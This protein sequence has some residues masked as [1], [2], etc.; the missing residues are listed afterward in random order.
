LNP[1]DFEEISEAEFLKKRKVELFY[2]G[3][4]QVLGVE[5]HC[6]GL[7][8]YCSAKVLATKNKIFKISIKV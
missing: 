1:L 7:K 8:R 4:K 6:F 3:V 5:E 2:S